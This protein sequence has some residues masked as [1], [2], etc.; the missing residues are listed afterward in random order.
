MT[1]PEPS[2]VN[3]GQQAVVAVVVR[4]APAGATLGALP[5][6]D[7]LEIL[8]GRPIAD[9]RTESLTW[10]VTLEPRREGTFELPP[11]TVETGAGALA[12]PARQL[13]AARDE[14]AARLAFVDVSTDRRT[15]FVDETVALR[16][17]FG[18]ASTAL[19]K[20]LVRLFRQPLD[21][22]V[23]VQGPRLGRLSGASQVDGAEGGSGDGVRFVLNDDVAE[24]RRLADEE[25]EGRRFAVFEIVRRFRFEEPGTRVIPGA[26][27]RFAY[28]TKF[29]EDFVQGRVAEDRRS[30]V[31]TASA[32]ALTIVAPP[33]EG[34]PEDFTGAVGQFTVAAAVSSREERSETG[35]RLTMSIRGD[36][37]L[38]A[39]VPPSLAGMHGLTV[40]DVTKKPHA[41]GCEVEYALQ[42]SDLR[43]IPAIPFTY[44]EPGP[45]S[46]YRTV[47]TN[48]IPLR[49]AETP[50]RTSAAARISLLAADL[51][52][53]DSPGAVELS[54]EWVGVGLAGPWIFAAAF[55][56]W[57]RRQRRLERAAPSARRDPMAAF[58]EARGRA[59][60]DPASALVAYL[61]AR[62][63]RSEASIVT[64]GLPDL[65]VAD[66]VSPRSAARAARLLESLLAARYGGPSLPDAAQAVEASVASLEAESS[67]GG[68]G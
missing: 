2:R 49:A 19:Q 28:A 52:A 41:G 15:A 42:V 63:A 24:A 32:S 16:V 56:L 57:R 12:S 8:A 5:E 48:P 40:R 59:S 31:V 35:V 14:A 26:L 43:E 64:T 3:V 33:R 36:G 21:L 65:L 37:D 10:Q 51:K 34:R 17:R 9:A 50:S 30:G 55:L 11:F 58:R 54:P 53:A 7:G 67:A 45:P 46:R 6:I 22:Q 23:Q 25:R 62:L 38:S 68:R 66:G 39:F 27:M 4:G 20:N 13:E 18:V 44:L 1:G 61:T 47:L 29:R 60:E